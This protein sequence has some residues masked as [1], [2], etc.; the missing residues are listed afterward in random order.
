M[1]EHDGD[2]KLYYYD[3]DSKLQWL[4]EVDIQEGDKIRDA[5]NMLIKSISA[6]S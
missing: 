2:G 5:I 3:K 1:I 4:V 6:N